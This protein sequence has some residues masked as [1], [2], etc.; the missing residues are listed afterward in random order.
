MSHG[1][2]I[3]FNIN[4]FKLSELSPSW[5]LN[6]TEILESLL[7]LLHEDK[8]QDNTTMNNVKPDHILVF[9]PAKLPIF[10]Y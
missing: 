6:V 8:N 1:N 7:I 10:S 5:V 3:L 9:W 4:L 2:I